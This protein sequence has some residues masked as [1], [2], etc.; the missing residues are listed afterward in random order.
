MNFKLLLVIMVVVQFVVIVMVLTLPSQ[1]HAEEIVIK[2]DSR[3]HP[4][5]VQVKSVCLEGKVFAVAITMNRGTSNYPV[6]ITQVYIPDR[7]M[8]TGGAQPMLCTEVG[9]IR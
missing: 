2:V 4:V 1:A 7:S 3:T 9:V 5:E 8:G 6:A